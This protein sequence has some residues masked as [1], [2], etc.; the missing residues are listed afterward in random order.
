MNEFEFGKRVSRLHHNITKIEDKAIKN[1][2]SHHNLTVNEMLLLECIKSSTKGHEGPTIST[3]AAELD[4]TR[5]S[6]TVAVNKLTAKKFVEKTECANDGRSVRVKLTAKGEK[7]FTL[8]KNHS[9]AI[10]KELRADVDDEQYTKLTESIKF[11]E[12]YFENRLRTI[13]REEDE[14]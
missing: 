2:K 14:F 4:I 6:T 13:E 5:P 8:H 1:D 7:A 9:N 12:E 11:L 10:A 3:I